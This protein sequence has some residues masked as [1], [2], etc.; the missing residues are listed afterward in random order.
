[1]KCAHE[2]L[3]GPKIDPGL[4]TN[5]GIDLRQQCRRNLDD[6]D[7]SHVKGSDESRN[8]AHN[9]TTQRDQRGL[10]C[11]AESGNA[12]QKAGYCPQILGPFAVRYQN[13][14]KPFLQILSNGFEDSGLGH[15]KKRAVQPGPFQV[16]F[17]VTQQTR[18][19]NDAVGRVVQ[20]D[21]NSVQG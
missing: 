12:I 18:P 14:G 11:H 7:S 19:N 1:M 16:F 9:S 15:N 13:D 6:G 3:D 5:T 8:V 20:P 17:E 4:S 2:I 21:R 10:S